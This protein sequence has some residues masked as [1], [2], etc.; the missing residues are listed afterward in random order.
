M[1]GYDII[2][3]GGSASGIV[4]ALTAKAYYPDKRVAVV[5]KEEV[6]VV[7][8]GI[9][10]LFGDLDSIDKN[11]I[12][13]KIFENNNITLI[14]DEVLSIKPEDYVIVLRDKGNLSYQKLVLATGSKPYVPAW[15]KGAGL[16]NV[17]TITK[18]ANELAGVV[19]RLKSAEKIVVIGGGFIGVEV[20]DELVAKSGKDVTL[21]EA[22]PYVLA[23]A[24][25]EPI[26]RMA[27][28]ILRQH[29]V[30]IETGVGVSEIIDNSGKAGGVVLNDG[31]RIDADAVVLAMGYR[32]NVELA[33]SIGLSINSFGA[34]RVDEYMRT[35]VKDIFAV[36]DCAEK[37]DFITRRPNPVMLASTACAEARIAGVNLYGLSTVK[38]FNGTIAI[39]STRIGDTAFAAAGLIQTFAEK[40]GF[41]VLIAEFKGVDRHPGTLP[42]THDQFV[43]LILSPESG[44]VLGAEVVGG[45]S[46]GELINMLGVCIQARMD[47]VQLATMQIGSHPL[48]TAAPTAYP[49]IKAAEIGMRKLRK[50]GN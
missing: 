27:E 38:T 37:R 2:V 22:R 43:R 25:D 7:P 42:D 4:A 23:S 8:C 36:G 28:D 10:Y 30:K 47:V 46:C 41:D 13:T 14:V 33:D 18:S 19:D 20:S 39:F 32:P 24:F 1:D 6:A 29:G 12:P 15:L 49:V 11:V 44:V 3:I 45:V 50:P 21:I 5:R 48:L 17:F 31:R 26:A 16:E 40:E 34:I 9:P 35:Q